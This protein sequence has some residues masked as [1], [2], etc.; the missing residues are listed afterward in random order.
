MKTLFYHYFKT[1]NINMKPSIYLI[2]VKRKKNISVSRKKLKELYKHPY[3]L[4]NFNSLYDSQTDLS[5]REK[6][7]CDRK[8]SGLTFRKGN[9]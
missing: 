5:V 8:K 7:A 4:T 3:P 1:F 9:F 6:K 2:N